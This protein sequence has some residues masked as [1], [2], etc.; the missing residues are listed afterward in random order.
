MKSYQLNTE[1]QRCAD[2]KPRVELEYAN[3]FKELCILS[4]D[5][6]YFWFIFIF[7]QPPRALSTQSQSLDFSM[8]LFFYISFRFDRNN[9]Q[10]FFFQP[11]QQHREHSRLARQTELTAEVDCWV[12]CSKDTR[13]C[14]V[15]QTAEQNAFLLTS[16][17][18]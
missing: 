1:S 8:E 11:P 9:L 13:N 14:S 12:F 16:I 17:T 2:V 18:E 3:A 10:C 15:V 7:I 5:Y 4:I 6:T